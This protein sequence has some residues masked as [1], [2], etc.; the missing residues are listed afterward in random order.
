MLLPP[1]NAVMVDR[2]VS[3][4]PKIPGGAPIFEVEG[5]YENEYVG[6]IVL[7]FARQCGLAVRVVGGDVLAITCP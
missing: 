5:K 4:C 2:L 3:T 1:G 6:A 7:D